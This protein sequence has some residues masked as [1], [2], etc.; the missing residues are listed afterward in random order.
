[1]INLFTSDFF[2]GNREALRQKCNIDYPIVLSAHGSMQRTGDVAYP[3]R[4][5]SNF[6]YLTG[7][8]IPELIM[9]ISKNEDCIILP[10]RDAILDVFEGTIDKQKLRDISGIKN[11]YDQNEGWERL[12]TLA[13]KHRHFNVPLHKSYDDKH[14]LYFNPAKPKLVR[15]LKKLGVEMH[16]IRMHLVHMRMF[17]QKP[18]IEAIQH[19][20]DITIDSISSVFSENWHIQHDNEASI[21]ARVTYEY[22]KRGGKVSYPSIIAG[23]RRACTLHYIENNQPIKN[24]EMLL[25]DTGSEWSN[26]AADITRMYSASAYSVRQKTVYDAVKDVQAMAIEMIKPGV[27]IQK[28]QKAVTLQI[29]RFLKAEKLINKLDVHQIHAYYPHAVSHHL[30]LDV[31]DVADYS[32]P[33]SEGMVITVE[34]GIYIPEW[35]IGVRIEDDIL[36]TKSGA[37]VMSDRLPS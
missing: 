34:P 27:S 1:V 29:G 31:H 17:K 30:G 15:Q 37:K 13:K 32:I 28:L 21:D 14:N 10:K 36:V 3:F 23:G 18:E 26:Y 8:E 7:L 25:I 9:V 2:V 19:A 16:D 33:L 6:W 12:R 5:E 35:G 24:N 20:V 11:I 22:A 4:Q